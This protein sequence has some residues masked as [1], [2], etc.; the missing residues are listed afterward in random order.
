[1]F[2]LPVT[3]VLVMKLWCSLYSEVQHH[4]V[5]RNLNTWTLKAVQ[6]GLKEIDWSPLA[7]SCRVLASSVHVN[8]DRDQPMNNAPVDQ[9]APNDIL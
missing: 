3:N 9:T 1:M 8:S 7:F 5:G 2:R 4:A 6:R